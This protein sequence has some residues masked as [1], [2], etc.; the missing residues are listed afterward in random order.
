MSMTKSNKWG[1]I[2]LTLDMTKIVGFSVMAGVLAMLLFMGAA[3]LLTAGYTAQEQVHDLEQRV[4]AL[5]AAVQEHDTGTVRM[6][7]SQKRIVA[8]P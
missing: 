2:E 7:R 5:E 6:A 1:W 4:V 3:D 8:Q